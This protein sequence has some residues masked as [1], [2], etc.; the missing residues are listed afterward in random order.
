MGNFITVC[1]FSRLAKLTSKCFCGK[2]FG[3]VSQLESHTEQEHS[4]SSLGL[5]SLDMEHDFTSAIKEES[6]VSETTSI[7]ENKPPLSIIHPI[8]ISG[9]VLL[10]PTTSKHLKTINKG[11]ILVTHKLTPAT[12]TAATT[13]SGKS[14]QSSL[15]S[16]SSLVTPPTTPQKRPHIAT[17]TPTS[18]ASGL[19]TKDAKIDEK[20]AR[21]LA[22]AKQAMEAAAVGSTNANLSQSSTQCTVV[23]HNAQ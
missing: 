9:G 10:T 11:E 1:I 23:S 15:V 13:N 16:N 17:T 20:V 8:T 12:T 22:A 14:I 19:L 2:S 6:Q 7:T 18:I 5:T 3:S 4:L 21:M